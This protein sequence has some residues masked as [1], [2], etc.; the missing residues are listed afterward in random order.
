MKKKVD[1]D[2]LIDSKFN[3]LLLKIGEKIYE[4]LDK[5]YVISLALFFL[6]LII[7]GYNLFTGHLY[8]A[9]YTIKGGI[10]YT[11]QANENVINNLSKT[12]NVEIHKLNNNY[13]FIIP[14]GENINKSKIEAT[15]NSLGIKNYNVEETSSLLSSAFFKTLIGLVIFSFILV[16]IS[17]FLI[18]KDVKIASIAGR[19]LFFNIFITFTLTN[20]FIPLS[21]YVIPAYLMIIGYGIDTNLILINHM[22][23]EKKFELKKRFAL[24][25]NTGIMIHLTTL[26]VLLIGIILANNLVFKYI[27]SI[28][29]VGL[30][31]DIVDTWFLNGYLIKKFVENQSS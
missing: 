17:L 23:K 31:I 13:Y 21:K 15:L 14:K 8:N 29:A 20:L 22:L 11:F 30:L 5:L 2:F 26:T 10:K 1:Y 19:A 3:R 16:I 25:F 9:D 7:F 28:L 27:F 6:S 4:K 24:A 18:Y 12:L